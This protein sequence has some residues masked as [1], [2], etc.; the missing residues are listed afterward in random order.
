MR[1]P[2]V[3]VFSLAL[4]LSALG[5]CGGDDS[6]PAKPEAVAPAPAPSKG[7]EAAPKTTADPPSVADEAKKAPTAEPTH[8][9]DAGPQPEPV[10][11]S[12]TP[13]DTEPMVELAEA[14]LARN[15]DK[16]TRKPVEPGTSFD[17]AVDAVW[18]YLS[19]VNPGPETTVVSVW[20]HEGV[21]RFRYDLKIGPKTKGWRT[22]SR[23]RIRTRDKDLGSWTCDILDANGTLVQS[24]PFTV[25]K[26]GDH[27]A[28]V[29]ARQTH[30]TSANAKGCRAV[31]NVV[32]Q[33]YRVAD[34]TIGDE[35]KLEH[36][37][38]IAL[39][40]GKLAWSVQLREHKVVDKSA[41]GS[42]ERNWQDVI[43]KQ[44]PDGKARTW[45]DTRPD[46]VL[47]DDDNPGG[48]EFS[49]SHHFGV[50]AAFGPYLAVHEAI[51]GYSGGAHE[52][53]GS[54]Y[55]TYSAPLG[56]AANPLD[57][58]AASAIAEVEATLK[59]VNAKRGGDD[60]AI[61]TPSAKDLANS[62]IGF[63]SGAKGHQVHLRHLVDCC[64]W[65]ENHNMFDLD[66]PLSTVPAAWAKYFTLRDG[67]VS[68]PNR[69][70]SVQVK[71][72][73]LL[74]QARQGPK[75]PV[76]LDGIAK[77]DRLLGVTWISTDHPFDTGDLLPPLSAQKD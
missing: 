28:I 72:G 58:L 51:G 33:G 69:C 68:A 50:E 20:K 73:K 4:A 32:A 3:L 34:I 1:R 62:A 30:P 76:S 44:L 14:T 18:V 71:D 17:S 66:V 46:K 9:P 2:L 22:W 56:K 42:L 23:Q 43:A 53:D 12:T 67:M 24:F 64:T 47:P 31:V 11:R 38:G 40:D 19:V 77:V 55:R 74:V 36:A 8:V 35:V 48:P 13:P 29:A 65:A 60:E 21:E 59:V 52:Y 45:V 75:V 7:S 16:T 25:T 37:P 26:S 57:V 27:D 54:T 41:H 10:G 49:A 39:I 70:G 63:G 15:V 61:P 5:G 6:K